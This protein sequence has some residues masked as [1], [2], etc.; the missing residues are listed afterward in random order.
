VRRRPP[1]WRTSPTPASVLEPCERDSAGN[2]VPDVI[3]ARH[4]NDL[5]LWVTTGLTRPQLVTRYGTGIVGRL[6]ERAMVI[7]VGAA[8]VE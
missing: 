8:V 3:F 4:A 1:P 5:P 6:F 7:Q 2:A